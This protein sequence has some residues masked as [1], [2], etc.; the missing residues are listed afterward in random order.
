MFIHTTL[1]TNLHTDLKE[2]QQDVFVLKPFCFVVILSSSLLLI[3]CIAREITERIF[4]WEKK[5]TYD[6]IQHCMCEKK[7]REIFQKIWFS[8]SKR[9]R[10]YRVTQKR[11]RSLKVFHEVSRLFS[12][13]HDKILL[14]K[15]TSKF[16]HES[17]FS[18]FSLNKFFV[19]VNVT[20]SAIS[21]KINSSSTHTHTMRY[22]FSS[23]YDDKSFSF[24]LHIEDVYEW[25]F[26]LSF[27]Y[28]LAT[29]ESWHRWRI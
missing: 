22:L 12:R 3:Y 26:S 19:V 11:I 9:A 16:P 17:C 8:K 28:L 27:G 1:Q 29:C 5:K 7:K 21:L 23:T 18:F 14:A 13:F 25:K 2:M 20:I 24:Y 4:Q 10:R 6:I 15:I